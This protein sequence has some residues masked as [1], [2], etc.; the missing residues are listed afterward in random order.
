MLQ[1]GAT[2]GFAKVMRINRKKAAAEKAIAEK[3]EEENKRSI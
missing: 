1:L 2:E 3:K